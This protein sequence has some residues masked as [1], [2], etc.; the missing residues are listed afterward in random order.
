MEEEMECWNGCW[1]F[2]ILDEEVQ[3]NETTNAEGD[4][5][6]TVHREFENASYSVVEY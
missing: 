2:T 4:A 6:Q 1:N 3:I 5:P